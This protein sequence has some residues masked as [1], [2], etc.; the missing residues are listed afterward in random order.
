MIASE[1]QAAV[2]NKAAYERTLVTLYLLTY[3]LFV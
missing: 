1:A 3:M 2:A